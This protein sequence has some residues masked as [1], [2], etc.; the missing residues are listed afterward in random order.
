MSI[1]AT[2]RDFAT[3]FVLRHL[4][5]ALQPLIGFSQSF[6]HYPYIRNDWHK[7]GIPLPTRHNVG[8][9]MLIYASSSYLPAI[10]TYIKAGGITY[11]PQKLDAPADYLKVLV[12]LL[13]RQLLQVSYVSVGSYHQ[14]TGIIRIAIHDNEVFVS[15][16]QDII[17][18]ILIIFRLFA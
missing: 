18:S 12:E 13:F 7:I 2:K 9:D 10:Y 17:S 8:M 14:V 6:R 4:E 1:P 15:P 11:F 16:V 5:P 3:C